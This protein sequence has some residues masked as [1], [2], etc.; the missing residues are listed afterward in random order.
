MGQVKY[1]LCITAYTIMRDSEGRKKASKA[2]QTTSK[3]T[4]HTKAFTFPKKNELPQ[5]VQ[6]QV[7]VFSTIIIREEGTCYIYTHV[8]VHVHVVYT[9]TCMYMVMLQLTVMTSSMK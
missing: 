1:M 8:H 6:V 2:M 9:C 3:A 5:H 4:Q 7:Y